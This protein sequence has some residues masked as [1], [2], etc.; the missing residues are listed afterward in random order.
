MVQLTD[1]QRKFGSLR[2]VRVEG[3]FSC[4]NL[5]GGFERENVD[6]GKQDGINDVRCGVEEEG[7]GVLEKEKR[8]RRPNC[9]DVEEEISAREWRLK[10][11]RHS[12]GRREDA[13]EEV[14]R[15]KDSL[16]HARAA[17]AAA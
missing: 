11:E 7:V 15:L 8:G 10:I 5:A 3:Q 12:R 17:F 9:H 13:S 14:P 6:P 4:A 1:N 2:G 16:D